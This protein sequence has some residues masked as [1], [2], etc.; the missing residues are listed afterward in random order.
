MRKKENTRKGKHWRWWEWWWHDV[1]RRVEAG[2]GC[3][4]IVN[5]LSSI[6]LQWWILRSSRDGERITFSRMRFPCFSLN[7][8]LVVIVITPDATRKTFQL[9]QSNRMAHCMER[10]L[11]VHKPTLVETP[12]SA[13]HG[14]KILLSLTMIYSQFECFQHF[15]MESGR[16][17]STAG[18]WW[19][20]FSMLL[21]RLC[22]AL[23]GIFSFCFVLL[24]FSVE[25]QMLPP[26]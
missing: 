12:T 8:S 1:S 2:V 6:S 24:V 11:I 26:E 22:F 9:T 4:N 18:K 7:F 10:I 21:L 13:S 16:K 25:W 14:R 5:L 20:F 15:S 17:T 23:Y 19:W 3:R